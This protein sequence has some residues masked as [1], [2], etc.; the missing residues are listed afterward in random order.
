MFYIQFKKLLKKWANR[1]FSLISSFLVSDVS[2]S[3]ISLKSNERCERIAQVAHQKWA[4]MSDSLRSLRGN[5]RSWANRSGRSPKM[6]EWVNRSFF[7]ANRS[8]AYFWAKNERF[9]RKTD[10]RIPSPARQLTDQMATWLTDCYRRL[11]VNAPDHSRKQLPS[12]FTSLR[13]YWCQS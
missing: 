9:A 8:F 13:N 6:S 5:E 1:S 7:W 4:T 2:E 12:V 10:E 11:G 3:L